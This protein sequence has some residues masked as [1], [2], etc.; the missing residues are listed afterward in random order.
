M[1]MYVHK[2]KSVSLR[3]WVQ[4]ILFNYCADKDYERI[5][6]SFANTNYCLGIIRDKQISNNGPLIMLTEKPGIHSYLTGI[7]L[8]HYNFKASGVQD[9]I[10]IDFTPAGYHC[11]FRFPPKTFMLNDNILTEAFGKDANGYFEKVFDEPSLV[12]RGTLIERFLENHLRPIA[13][14][15]LD[16]ALLLVH[17]RHGKIDVM[18]LSSSL[19]WSEKKLYRHFM[20][21]L[22]ISPKEY[23]RVTRFRY[24]LNLLDHTCDN[25]A[26]KAYELGFSDQSHFIREIKF[27]T[28]NTPRNAVRDIQTIETLLKVGLY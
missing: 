23:C 9:E 12:A 14:R 4:Y 15:G 19:K 21:Y 28:G 26:A 20:H 8:N 11:F 27:F 5:I 6:R 16:E 2:I 18:E 17:Q 1:K 25:F 13:L 10:C 24:A 7:Y 22:D 3:P